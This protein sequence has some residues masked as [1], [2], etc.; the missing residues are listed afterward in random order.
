MASELDLD[1]YEPV[2]NTSWHRV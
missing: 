2:W 1:F